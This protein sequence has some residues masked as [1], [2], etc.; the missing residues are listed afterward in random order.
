MTVSRS[1]GSVAS[2]PAT[3]VRGALPAAKPWI[4]LLLLLLSLL[5]LRVE[6]LLLIDHFTFTSLVQAITS[7]P[8]AVVILV[9]QRSL[10]R[11]YTLRR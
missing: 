8:L 9:L 7:H 6:I 4:P 11:R 2:A 10:W 5:D 3:Q 1:S